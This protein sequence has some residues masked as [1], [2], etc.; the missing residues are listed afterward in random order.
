[1][2][3]TSGEGG[4]HPCFRVGYQ[5]VAS[6]ARHHSIFHPVLDPV[7]VRGQRSTASTLEGVLYWTGQCAWRTESDIE[8]GNVW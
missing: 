3:T 7:G 5:K 6:N 4:Q 8:V 1:V 2:P